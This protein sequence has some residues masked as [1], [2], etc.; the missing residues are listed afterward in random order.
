M[1]FSEY[2]ELDAIALAEP[3][4]KGEVSAA[5]AEALVRDAI[6]EKYLLFNQG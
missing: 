4:S 6:C 1:D 3:I 2:A 5:E